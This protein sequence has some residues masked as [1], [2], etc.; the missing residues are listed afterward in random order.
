MTQDEIRTLL[1][2]RGVQF[3]EFPVQNGMQFRCTTNGE[4][5]NVFDTGKI[6]IQ[7]KRSPLSDEIRQAA[8]GSVTAQQATAA[9]LAVE[10]ASSSPTTTIFIVYGHD[11]LARDSLDL[12]LRRF[13]LNPIILQHIPA[14]G[15][16]IIEK[17]EQY[18]GQRGSTGYACV[19]LTPDDEGHKAGIPEERQYR[20][21]QNVVLELGMVLAR[22]GRRN[23]AILHKG[24]VELPSDISGLIYIPFK[25]RVDEVRAKLF[26]Q[27]RAA[28]YT[29]NPEGL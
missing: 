24:S 14:S 6:S 22:L 7:G 25:E 21:R 16:T 4:I 23:V 3:Q 13:G 15:D 2:N 18:I 29:V 28:G 12:L 1:R 9:P 19:L 5:F 26:Q 8:S 27:L 10:L 11:G 17:L 20:A